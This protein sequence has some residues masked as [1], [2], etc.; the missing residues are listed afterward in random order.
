MIWWY[1]FMIG[2]ATSAALLYAFVVA[3]LARLRRVMRGVEMP[4]AIDLTV[5]NEQM[6]GACQRLAALREGLTETREELASLENRE[7]T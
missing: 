7:A 3:D 6:S 4:V 1:G 5:F 2:F